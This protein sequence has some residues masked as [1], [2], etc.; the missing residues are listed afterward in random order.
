VII[1][2]QLEFAVKQNFP[3]PFNPSTT[4]K[5]SIAKNVNRELEVVSLVVYDI[6]GKEVATLVNKEQ[7]AGNYEVMFNASNLSSGV[8]FYRLQSG[9]FVETKKL[10]LL[11]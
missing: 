1:E 10:M 5:Y 11:R 4:I 8:Y 3:N 6:L 2:E 9:S 7:K